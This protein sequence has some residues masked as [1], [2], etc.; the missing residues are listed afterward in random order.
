LDSFTVLREAREMKGHRSRSPVLLA[1][2]LVGCLAAPVWADEPAPAPPNTGIF[3]LTMSLN[4]PTS[5]YFR[6]IAQ[7]NAGFHFQPY[8]ELK[9]NVY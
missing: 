1:A 4:F 5:Y 9:A 8:V 3:A 6:G 7:S 2:M